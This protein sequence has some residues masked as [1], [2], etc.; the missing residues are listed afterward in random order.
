MNYARTIGRVLV[1]ALAVLA[2]GGCGN[3][4]DEAQPPR[5]IDELAVGDPAAQARTFNSELPLTVFVLHVDKDGG[6]RRRR[7]WPS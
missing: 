2:A 1:V 4:N 5:E 3:A 7:G 6:G